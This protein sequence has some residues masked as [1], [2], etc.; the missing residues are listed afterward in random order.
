[1]ADQSPAEVCGNDAITQ[2]VM[3]K[4][5]AYFH[6]EEPN[7]GGDGK[8]DYSAEKK[9]YIC[10]INW[11]TLDKRGRLIYTVKF[12]PPQVEIY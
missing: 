5:R 6:D 4:L 3:A 9:T 2:T 7:L 10:A 1:M 8:A 11:Q 12:N